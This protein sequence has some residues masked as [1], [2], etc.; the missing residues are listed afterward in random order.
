MQGALKIE[1]QLFEYQ[2]IRYVV[3]A[4][5]VKCLT[6]IKQFVASTRSSLYHVIR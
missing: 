6:C 2:L 1:N 3:M 5:K 4:K